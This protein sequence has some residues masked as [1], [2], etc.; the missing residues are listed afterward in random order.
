MWSEPS[1]GLKPGRLS[2]GLSCLRA[3]C[4]V[5]NANKKNL[6]YSYKKVAGDQ[7]NFVVY[8]LSAALKSGGSCSPWP[9]WAAEG[10]CVPSPQA[11]R[12]TPAPGR[13][14]GRAPGGPCRVFFAGDA[15]GTNMY[16]CW[17]ARRKTTVIDK[18]SSKVRRHEDKLA[19]V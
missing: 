10:K 4:L 19:T 1:S 5:R 15:M 9:R 17:S 2:G 11:C 7:Q 18:K 8:R 14:P 16:Q 3:E 13:A 12:Q 6:P